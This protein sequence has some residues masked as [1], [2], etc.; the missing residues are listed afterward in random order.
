MTARRDV[1]AFLERRKLAIVGV[2]RS[3]QGFGNS[4]YKELKT[5]GYQIYPVHPEA[6]MIDGER[7]YP[8]LK[9]LPEPVEG[10]LIVLP[11][12]ET[13]KVVQEAA[14]AGI[15]HVWMQQGAES[16]AAIRFC[17][18]Q[19]INAVHGECVLMFAEPTAF[20]HRMHRCV[21][22]LLGRLPE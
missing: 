8:S 5:K 15:R 16:V 12:Q 21:W 18:E 9:A 20:F 13:E 17:E 2:S 11:P 4:A 19:G 14:E 1:D 22:G 6:D 7:C 3:G 10:L